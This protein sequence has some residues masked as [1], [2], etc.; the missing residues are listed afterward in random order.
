MA[1]SFSAATPFVFILLLSISSVTVHGASH[2]HT[3]APA[4]A[5]DCSTLIIN[6]ADCL[7]FVTAGGTSAKP[8]SSCCAG[9]KTV[10]KA[11]AECLCEAFK[12][13]AAFGITLNMT[14]AATLPTACKLHAP[15]ISNCGL[16]MTPTMA[17]VSMTP[18]MA[19]GLAP[20]GA[21]AAGPGAAGT[22]LAPTP[23]QGN[24]GSCLIPISFTTLFSA[25]F[26]VLFL[27]R[28]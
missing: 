20:G 19:P 7:D 15:S 17:P 10:L 6:M 26:F 21:V 11:D 2:H 12:N 22:T 28:M 5:V 18:T 16:S 9:L 8:K 25:L 4:P 1:T 13:S 23:S 14:K 24:D 3:A 27:S